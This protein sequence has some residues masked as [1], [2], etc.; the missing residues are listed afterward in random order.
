MTKEVNEAQTIKIIFLQSTFIS[1]LFAKRYS[2]IENALHEEKLI[3][4]K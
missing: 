4:P 3:E 1:R 2:S